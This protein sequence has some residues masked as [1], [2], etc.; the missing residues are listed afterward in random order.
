MAYKVSKA[1]NLNFTYSNFT[2]FTNIRSE[3]VELN[4]LT[5][6]ENLD[7]LNFTQIAQTFTLNANYLINPNSKKLKQTVNVFASYQK[8]SDKQGDEIQ[9][10]G[11]EF[12]N[13]NV[14]FS[15]N[16]VKKGLTVVLAV[17]TNQNKTLISTSRTL[18]PTIAVNKTMLKR[19]LRSSLSISY[20]NSYLDEKKTGSVIN[21]RLSNSFRLKNKHQFSLG[22]VMLN[23][24]ATE[25][26]LSEFSEY[27]VNFGY[28]IRF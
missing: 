25:S 10:S 17:N 19:K 11:A 22:I 23:K 5:P 6:F 3:F 13:A 28:G 8:A 20:N 1:L 26:D 12:Y 15:N 7:T 16:L 9:N 14:S 4:S 24:L 18:G 21:Y 2:T 27:T